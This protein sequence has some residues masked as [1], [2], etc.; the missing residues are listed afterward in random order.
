MSKFFVPQDYAAIRTSTLIPDRV[1]GTDVYALING[2]AV[3]WALGGQSLEKSRIR[4]LRD[5]KI[6]KLLIQKSDES[7]YRSYIE[8]SLDFTLNDPNIKVEE[9]VN[10]SSGAAEMAYD[11]LSKNPE[12]EASYKTSSMYFAKLG[13]VLE[14][15][16]DGIGAV[17]KIPFVA[18]QYDNAAH[19]LQVAALSLSLCRSMGLIR[20]EDHRCAII[21]GCF[22]HDLALDIEGLARQDMPMVREARDPVWLNHTKKAAAL[23]GDKNHVHPQVLE[24]ILQHEES[25]DGKG[26]PL[27]LRANEMDKVALIVGLCN[28]FEHQV[29]QQ[30]GDRFKAME[31]LFREQLGCYELEQLSA[32]QKIVHAYAS[33]SAKSDTTE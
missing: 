24:I 3:K 1:L 31:L 19:G 12:S 15:L 2:K 5:F 26:F 22:M 6:R 21:T 32:L 8:E 33:P 10:A 11:E 9:K 29:V 23:M 18:E 17:L 4:K 14:S 30:N 25:P 20:S 28:R 16:E 7:A 27:G 13:H